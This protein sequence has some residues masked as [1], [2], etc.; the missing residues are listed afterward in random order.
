MPGE[1]LSRR[2]V[3]PVSFPCIVFASIYSIPNFRQ[4]D[5]FPSGEVEDILALS[6][7]PYFT[8]CPNP[9]LKDVIP[10]HGRPYDPEEPYHSE[11]F[12]LDVAEGKNDTVSVAHSDHTN[13]IDRTTDDLG[14]LDRTERRGRLVGG[15]EG[16]RRLDKPELVRAG[17]PV[18]VSTNPGCV[19]EL[20]TDVRVIPD[21]MLW[22]LADASR[23]VPERSEVKP[24]TS[25][26]C[27]RG[28]GP[29][30]N[31][32]AA[33]ARRTSLGVASPAL[34]S[35]PHRAR[36]PGLARPGP[37]SEGISRNPAW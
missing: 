20:D 16:Q 4:G 25:P 37:G 10:H 1:G 32:H 14:H 34:P 6:D 2:R 11:P 19:P 27:Q 29:W 12:A 31:A 3:T 13:L 7:P 15:S 5:G 30:A 8:A 9:F 24:F 23:A 33:N 22:R 21:N 28:E 36:V 35:L 18:R 26:M 17:R